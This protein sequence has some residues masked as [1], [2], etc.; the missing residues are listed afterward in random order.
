MRPARRKRRIQTPVVLVVPTVLAV[1]AVLSIMAL[2]MAAPAARAADED[3]DQGR[4]YA[5]QDRAFRMNHEFSLSI[6]FLPLDAFYKMFS[7]N[8]HY[9][10]HFDDLWAWEAIH[11]GFSKYLS[12]DTGLKG[13][14]NDRWET[15]PTN[16]KESLIDFT[17]DTNLMLKPLYGKIV[18]FDDVVIFGETYFLLGA[19]AEKFQTAWFPALNVGVGLRIFLAETISIRLE[20]REYVHFGESI[21]GTLVFALGFSYNAFASERRPSGGESGV[22]AEV[23]K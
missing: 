9:V 5:I 20:V 13:E 18:L 12:V 15:Q 19:A 2:L 10:V 16:P 22:G 14:M 17:L 21:G 11:L 1:L 7:I 6:G 23:T 8:G 4:V 3:L